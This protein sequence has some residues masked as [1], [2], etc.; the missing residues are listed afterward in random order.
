MRVKQQG[1]GEKPALDLGILFANIDPY[2]AAKLLSAAADIV[3]VVNSEGIISDKALYSSEYSSEIFKDWVGKSWLDT[4]TIESRQK[5]KEMLQDLGSGQAARWRQVNHTTPSG[6]DFPVRYI[7]V[8]VGDD[9]YAVAVGRDMRTV[10][11][12]QQRLVAAELSIEQEYARLRHAETRYRLLMQVSTEA[13]LLVDGRSGRVV[14]ANPSAATLLNR[15]L[16]RLIGSVFSDNFSGSDIGK[17]EDMVV[18]LRSS[19]RMDEVALSLEGEQQAVASATV[20]R[21]DNAIYYLVRLFPLAVGTGGTVVSRHQSA[22]IQVFQ[23][24]PDG[25]VLTDFDRKILSANAA[26]LESAQ[27][28]TEEQARGEPID[29]WLGRVGVDTGLLYSNVIENGMVRQFAT[30]MRG[31]FGTVED[32]EVSGFAAKDTDPPTIGFTLRRVARRQV[33]EDQSKRSLLRSVD[34]MTKLVGKVP[35]KDLV[36]ETTDIIERLCIEAALQLNDNNRASSADMLGLSRQSLYVKL[37][38]HGIED[39]GFGEKD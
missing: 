38:R 9:G 15:P 1:S 21:E 31:Q 20:F 36:R 35:L 28:G 7:L 12:M 39:K 11:D 25:F 16:K 22:A 19:G 32:V 6:T 34:E 26:F 29:R 17:I 24:M 37:H 8:K 2:A 30:V 10:A 3:F 14:E 4:V 13:I 23:G 27:L 18:T 33:T 5:I